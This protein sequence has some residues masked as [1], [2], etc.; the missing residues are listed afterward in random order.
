METEVLLGEGILRKSRD[1]CKGTET[2][3]M[4]WCNINKLL[5]FWQDGNLY[6]SESAESATSVR[7]TNGGQN[8][9]HGIFD[10]VYKEEIY[11]RDDKAVFWSVMGEKL[12]FL[13]QEV[14]P[15]EKSIY[16][17]SYSARSNY[18]VMVELKYPK[19]H[20]K[21]LPTYVVNIWDKKTRELKQMDVQLR[22]STAFHYIFRAKWIV[23][24]GKEYLVVTFANRLQT[25]I[26]I[27]I[28]DH[29]SGMCKLVRCL[30]I[31]CELL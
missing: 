22:D 27:T 17:T 4:E 28:C 23:M 20:E 1:F 30:P 16:M 8:W 10:W 11:E 24:D 5:I 26:S 19:T 13:S 31:F 9:A 25:G 29:E 14:N 12:A 15:K 21:Y 3:R 18:P 7:I 6:Y 2:N